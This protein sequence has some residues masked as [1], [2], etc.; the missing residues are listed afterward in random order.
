MTVDSTPA[1]MRPAAL[2][3][4][5]ISY[6]HAKDKPVGAA[7]Q[8]AMQ[9]LG[10]PWYQRRALRIFRDNHEVSRRRPSCGRRLRKRSI[11]RDTSSSSLLPRFARSKWC[12]M[13]VAHWLM[14]KELSTLL[15]AVTDGELRW[16]AAAQD[17][18]WDETTPLPP[19]LR[20][21]YRNEPK[22]IDLR[23]FRAAPDARDA[24]FLD[25]AA[26]LASAVHGMPKEDLLSQEM[27]QQKRALRLAWGAAASLLVLAGGAGWQ[28]RVAV[29]ERDRAEYNLKL[30]RGAADDLV[31]KIAQGLRNVEGM[32]GIK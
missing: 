29:S 25:A 8:T 26:D 9:K 28:W 6:N 27:R 14:H 20:G 32:R 1:Q 17:F 15:I 2:Y 3:D 31:F 30:A 11:K 16:D 18:V 5:F 10:K 24:K 19:V 22:W 7:L 21:I 4:A 13:E 12:A 23:A